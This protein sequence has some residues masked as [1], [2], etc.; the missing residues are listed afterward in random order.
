[1]KLLLNQHMW[2]RVEPHV[3]HQIVL[4]KVHGSP[5]PES[6]GGR[7]D[8]HPVGVFGNY[9]AF[10]WPT[11]DPKFRSTFVKNGR[12]GAPI[13]KVAL[14]SGGLF[15]EAVL[16]QANAA[17]KIDLTRFRNWKDSRS[18]EHTSELQSLMRNSYSVFC[19]KQKKLHTSKT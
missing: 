8:P 13:S 4:D 1:M 2:M 18:E 11:D 12:A 9:V 10:R 5:K 15:A 17:E 16:G 14:P 7:M 6:L 19:L 3:W